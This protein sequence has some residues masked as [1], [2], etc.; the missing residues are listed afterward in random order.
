MARVFVTGSA[1]GLGL[2]AARLMV[3]DGHRV[4][5]HAR[6]EAR[7]AE[8]LSAVPGAE[9]AVA[10]DLSSIAECR[11]I[12]AD[13]N[14]LGVFDAVIHNAGVGYR[15][16]QR[17]TIDGLPHVFAINTLAPYV[18]TALIQKPKRLV[19]LSSGMHYSGDPRLTDLA[20]EKRKWNGSQ[21]YADSKLHDVLWRSPWPASGQTCSRTPWSLVGWRRRW[22]APMRPTTSRRGPRPRCGSQ[23]ATKRKQGSPAGTSTTRSSANRFRRHTTP[24]FRS[25][26]WPNARGSLASNFRLPDPSHPLLLGTPLEAAT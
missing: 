20:W 24:K 6:S 19:Y 7:A 5:L 12:A 8:A 21:A 15:E 4:V 3:A 16:P 11:R 22:A 13:V 26:C 1:D 2:M 18:L 10:G 25:D 23:R 17:R 14:E 9:G